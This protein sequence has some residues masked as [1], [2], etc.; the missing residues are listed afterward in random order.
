MLVFEGRFSA[1]CKDAT[2]NPQVWLDLACGPS[3][4]MYL[5]ELST[6][7]TQKG[8]TTLLDCL[9]P[10]TCGG[11]WADLCSGNGLGA[12]GA[13]WPKSIDLLHIDCN[14]NQM[15]LRHGRLA[16]IF[17]DRDNSDDRATAC[18]RADAYIK[19]NF[20]VADVRNLAINSVGISDRL[21]VSQFQGALLLNPP[22]EP[23]VI[24]AA[25]KFAS[26]TLVAGSPL[27]ILTDPSD[28]DNVQLIRDGCNQ[29]FGRHD[30]YEQV[31]GQ[32]MLGILA[33]K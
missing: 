20:V 12:I 7:A 1:R 32:A 4:A 21:P 14:D 27:A 11:I 6:K 17:K 8:L 28:T 26:L 25:L 19:E 9:P 3:F 2:P 15:M 22:G 5:T 13:C 10:E 30:V 18:Q 31:A 33:I 29:L 24:D 23:D 16:W